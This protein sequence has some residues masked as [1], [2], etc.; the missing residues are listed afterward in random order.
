MIRLLVLA[1]ALI[2]PSEAAVDEQSK[3]IIEDVA[4]IANCDGTKQRYVVM[5]PSDFN[6]DQSHDALIALHGHGSNRWQFVRDKRGECRAAR[7]VAAKHKM[8]Y[9]S[10]DY[11]AKT[12]W[13]GPQ[14]EADTVQIIAEIKRKYRMRKIY[15]C[16]GSMGGS[17][18]LTFAALHPNL[19]AGVASMNGTANHLEYENFS[20]AIQES[21]GGT[22]TEIPEEYKKRS[23]EYWPERFTMPVGITVGGKDESVPPQSVLRLANVLKKL[24]KDVLLIYRKDGG[25]STTYNNAKAIIEFIIKEHPAATRPARSADR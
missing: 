18:A 24:Q 20:E 1:F 12:S 15:L 5:M 13:M 25:H 19:I 10:P 9:V 16:G 6:E 3:W 4:F 14:A 22:K 23:A 2:L 17:S 11:R 8:I 21:F 7:D